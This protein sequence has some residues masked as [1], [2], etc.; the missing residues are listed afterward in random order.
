VQG[1]KEGEGTTIQSP[2]EPGARFKS[3]SAGGWAWGAVFALH[4]Q[5]GSDERVDKAG[6]AGMGGLCGKTLV[7]IDAC[8]S[9]TAS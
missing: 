4:V 7:M 8:R 5:P 6:A 2:S 1:L 9:S 3:A